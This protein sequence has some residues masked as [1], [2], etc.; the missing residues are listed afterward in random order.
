MT[1]RKIMKAPSEMLDPDNLNAFIRDSLLTYYVSVKLDGYHC[2]LKEGKVLSG[3]MKEVFLNPLLL[4]LLRPAL[5]YTK[6]HRVVLMGELY[7]HGTPFE[8]LGALRS[9]K[10][11]QL[12][13]GLKLHVFD[14]MSLDDWES[15]ECED[16]FLTRNLRAHAHVGAIPSDAVVMIPQSVAIGA[17]LREFFDRV[18][19]AGY[20]GLMLTAKDGRY[21]HGRVTK[22][23]AR[24]LKCKKFDPIDGVV[25]A[26]EE[27]LTIP[28]GVERKRGPTGKLE[29]LA[30]G[31][32][33]PSGTFGRFRV[34]ITS[35]EFEGQT[36]SIGRWKGFTDAMG[37]EIWQNRD[38]YVGRHCRFEGMRGAKALPRIPKNFAWRDEK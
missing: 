11:K 27:G 12:P 13:L 18:V 1:E 5:E 33:V 15:G 22:K 32:K 4:E 29:P 16:D 9:K 31:S 2:V 38:D 19:G 3:A 25:E 17:D 34:R 30:K 36:M 28:E 10:P 8:A 6:T 24:I 7:A 37:D 21:K 14:T 35:G 23:D 26:V 20:E